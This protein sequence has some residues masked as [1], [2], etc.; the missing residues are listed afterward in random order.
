MVQQKGA[1][2]K[3]SPATPASLRGP[4]LLPQVCWVICVC[5]R[6]LVSVSVCV[7]VCQCIT[8]EPLPSRA[9]LHCCRRCVGMAVSWSAVTCARQPTMP[10]VWARTPPTWRPSS[11]GPAPTT[12]APPAG[13]GRRQLAACCSGVCVCP[14]CVCAGCM[15][16]EHTCVPGGEV[17]LGVE[18]ECCWRE[19]WVALWPV[20]AKRTP[21]QAQ[22]WCVRGLLTCVRVPVHPHEDVCLC[23]C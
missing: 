2:G 15:C 8:R 11:T 7:S 9:F 17:V 22:S 20:L 10:S 14:G 18:T 16:T 21:P 4:A 6:E 19:C 5:V 23:G 13:A 3:A 1:E 12:P